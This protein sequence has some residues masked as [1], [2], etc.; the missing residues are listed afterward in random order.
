MKSRKKIVVGMSGGVDS[1]VAALLLKQQGH[2]VIGVFMKNWEDDDDNEY[3][4]SRQDLIDAV[5][6][7]SS[8]LSRQSTLLLNTRIAYLPSFCVSIRRAVHPILTFYAM[9]KSSSRHFSTTH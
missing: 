8:D 5:S 6:V 7:A 2:D 1:S 3:C 4:S 9:L